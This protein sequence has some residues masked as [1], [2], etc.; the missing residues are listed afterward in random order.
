MCAIFGAVAFPGPAGGFLSL[1]F[2]LSSTHLINK[3]LQIRERFANYFL[4]DDG[5]GS[6][7]K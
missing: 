3:A 6:L 5:Q 2:F 4:S 7:A 1:F